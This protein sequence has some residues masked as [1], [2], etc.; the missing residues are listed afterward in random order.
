MARFEPHVHADQLQ[1]E[2]AH[3]VKRMAHHPSVVL[4]TSC[5]ECIYHDGG[6]QV[7]RA[8]ALGWRHLPLK[9][10]QQQHAEPHRIFAVRVAG[11]DEDRRG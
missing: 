11:H 2:L 8:V 1:A 10:F 9:P 4:Y 3:Q 5:N 6:G 7:R